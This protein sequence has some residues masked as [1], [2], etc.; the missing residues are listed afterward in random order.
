MA[1]LSR[2]P[3]ALANSPAGIASAPHQNASIYEYALWYHRLGFNVVPLERPEKGKTKKPTCK[4]KDWQIQR[5]DHR[6]VVALYHR[7]T[8]DKER[9]FAHGI[10]AIDGVN[11]IRHFDLDQV[12]SYAEAVAPLLA[13]LGL[14]QDYAWVVQSGSG[15]GYHICLCCT[16]DITAYFPAGAVDGPKA[17]YVGDPKGADPAFDHIELRWQAALTTL[18]P[19]RHWSGGRY[20]F[21]NARPTELPPSIPIDTVIAAFQRIAVLRGSGPSTQTDSAAQTIPPEVACAPRTEL[22]EACQ[23]DVR[24]AQTAL[25]NE[26]SLLSQAREGSRNM[27]LNRSAFALGQIVAAGLL[28]ETEV[29]SRLTVIARQIG[30]EEH[31]IAA[32]IKSGLVAGKAHPRTPS[33][34]EPGTAEAAVS[35][36]KAE[37]CS[38]ADTKPLIVINGRQEKEVVEEAVA[39]LLAA[40]TPPTLFVRLGRLVRIKR[41]ERGRTTIEAMTEAM[42]RWRLLECATWMK[43]DAKGNLTHA[44]PPPKVVQ[45]VLALGSWSFPA[46]EG[47]S[48]LPIV[49]AD[50]T[51][52]TVP[53]YDAQARMIY[54]PSPELRLGTVPE[55][56]T[57]EDVEQALARIWQA[58]G[59]F[60]YVSAAERANALALLLTPLLR[61]VIKRYVP[62][63][64]IDAPKQGTGKGLLT[65]FIAVTTPR[66]LKPSGFTTAR[67]SCAPSE[68]GMPLFFKELPS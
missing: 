48:E 61:Y 4:W 19:S 49:R 58:I 38:G 45:D 25:D 23:T 28:S 12:T 27:Q 39:A 46:L 32:T 50:G 43:Q 22:S 62:L 56:P 37:A 60:P 15:K 40:N 3:R 11:D 7:R 34:M 10:L 41:D 31:E 52:V 64:L 42:L 26:C 5:Q 8:H 24:W 53:G 20:T 17:V 35:E 36:K 14:P 33:T 30:L 66:G 44:S 57:R 6:D 55:Q 65:D 16:G 29:V 2:A 59:E 54:A 9:N 1:T 47:I 21:V 68:R 67:P 63:A 13:A 18:P 51:I